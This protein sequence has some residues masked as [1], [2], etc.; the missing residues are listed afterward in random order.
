MPVSTRAVDR[1]S[2]AKGP[3]DAPGSHTVPPKRAVGGGIFR[4]SGSTSEATSNPILEIFDA[5]V[6]VG[7]P[8]D[9]TETPAHPKQSSR[10]APA[11]LFEYTKEWN[12]ATSH[13]EKWEII[14]SIPPS[15]I[16]PLF[17]ISLTPAI[18]MSIVETLEVVLIPSRGSFPSSAS[19]TVPKSSIRTYVTSLP[20][21]DR[22]SFVIMFLSESERARIN[23]LLSE[24]GVAKSGWGL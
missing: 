23:S 3:N 12:A 13:M 5:S 2:R 6:V 11:T 14:S 18:L 9:A 4:P 15:A 8:T 17:G 1:S 24:V 7:D 16:K 22:F 10:P 21:I 19:S 20:S